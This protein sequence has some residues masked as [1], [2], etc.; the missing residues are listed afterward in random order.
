MLVMNENGMDPQGTSRDALRILR[1]RPGNHRDLQGPSR[2]KKSERPFLARFHFSHDNVPPTAYLY[3]STYF[4]NNKTYRLSNV[5][6][7]QGLTYLNI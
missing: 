3:F 1:E 4:F 7:I 5:L 6:I 2:E